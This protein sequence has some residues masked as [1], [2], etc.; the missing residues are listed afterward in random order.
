MQNK[1]DKVF[2][3]PVVSESDSLHEMLKSTFW[4]K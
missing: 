2:L 3:M 4:G 1:I